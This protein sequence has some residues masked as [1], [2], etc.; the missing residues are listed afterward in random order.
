MLLGELIAVA[1][2]SVRANLFR[3]ILTMLGIIIG[4]ASVI[5]MRAVGEGAQGAVDDQIEALGAGLLSIRSGQVMHQGVSQSSDTLTLDDV[6]A[7]ARDSRTLAAVT[8]ERSGMEQFKYGAENANLR[9]VGASDNFMEVQSYELDIGRAL[10]AADNAAKRAVVVL[11]SKVPEKL[12][13]D[14]DAMLGQ[15]LYIR[16]LAFDVIGVLREKGT[17]GF[18]NV[19]EQAWVPL[20]TA[21]FR[22]FGTETLDL[23]SAKPIRGVPMQKAIID[24]ERVMRR[25]HR[26]PP[27]KD[28]D[29]TIQDPRQFLEFQQRAA[30]I[31]AA[32]LASIASITLIVG[33]IGIM[34]I[35]LVTVTERTRE[36]GIRMALGASRSSILVQFL[37][38]AMILCLLGG[39]IGILLG[40]G[41]AYGLTRLLSWKTTVSVTAIG[42]A[43]LFSAGVGLLFGLWPARKAARMDPITALRYE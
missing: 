2:Q 11:G 24:V 42:L 19:D 43:F 3:S 34:N 27:G 26:I 12:G 20:D 25:E 30:G 4:V 23:I 15:T 33:G 6:A 40:T 7:L 8:A 9:V 14:A 36:I 41:F 21:R 38:E 16:G 39:T 13:Q 1:L 10:T 37:I 22:L 17:S 32:L 31:F 18:R 28:N 5:T 29:F 35:M